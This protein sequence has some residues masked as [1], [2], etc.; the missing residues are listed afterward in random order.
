[1]C[2][3]REHQE[4]SNA[5]LQLP[6]HGR[7]I[8]EIRTRQGSV[9][10]TK[11]RIVHAVDDSLKVLGSLLQRR[12]SRLFALPIDPLCHSNLRSAPL[13]PVNQ[14]GAND[15]FAN[16][17]QPLCR[18]DSQDV[19]VHGAFCQRGLRHL[20]LLA[21]RSEGCLEHEHLVSEL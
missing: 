17:H 4:F 6:C 15:I 13:F 12:D 16:L 10:K 20:T 9:V 11:E 1:M 7:S 5:L 21:H 3:L 8:L 2:G 14:P 19:V 18:I